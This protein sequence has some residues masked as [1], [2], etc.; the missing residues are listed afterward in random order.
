MLAPM[1]S[2]TKQIDNSFFNEDNILGTEIDTTLSTVI[3][4]V[5]KLIEAENIKTKE[6]AVKEEVKIDE[7]K[8]VKSGYTSYFKNI[9][10][11]KKILC[12]F[13]PGCDHCQDTAKELHQMKLKDPS[14]P[15]V[16]IIFM[17]EEVDKIPEFFKIAGTKYPF[18]VIDIISFWTVLGNNR[19]T[20]GVKYLWN[21][22]EIKFYDGINANQFN[23]A[24]LKKTISKKY[25]EIKK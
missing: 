11:G 3:P 1:Q 20:P 4:T 6:E 23:G 19:D 2:K 21:G 18:Q 25:S 24:E 14:F 17:D 9:D 16:Y 10:Q 15:D 13:A 22:N 5:E 12:F 8:A 7:P